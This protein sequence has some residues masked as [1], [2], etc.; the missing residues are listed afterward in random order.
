[1][2]DRRWSTTA[3][4]MLGLIALLSAEA[5]NA[6]SAQTAVS[7]PLLVPI[8][9]PH[10]TAMYDYVAKQLKGSGA[11]KVSIVTRNGLK[12]FFVVRPGVVDCKG[13]REIPWV[14][15]KDRNFIEGA[16][17]ATNAAFKSKI[18]MNKDYG[19]GAAPAPVKPR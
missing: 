9:K 14:D 10:C 11:E 6:G 15:D 8:R 2:Q 17:K 13:Q 1:M 3:W 16:L 19:V 5:T 18:D 12:D 7:T 4:R